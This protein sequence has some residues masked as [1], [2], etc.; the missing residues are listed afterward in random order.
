[1]AYVYK[2]KKFYYKSYMDQQNDYKE[3]QIKKGDKIFTALQVKKKTN[4]IYC[5]RFLKKLV[6]TDS[7]TSTSSVDSSPKDIK[8]EF[9]GKIE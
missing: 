4:L 1:M 5:K 6:R 2:N 9:K 8:I 3:I 7:N